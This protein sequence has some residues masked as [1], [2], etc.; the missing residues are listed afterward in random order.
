M[1]GSVND[2]Y[3]H[4]SEEN[5]QLFL[6]KLL[7]K[8]VLSPGI[9]ANLMHLPLYIYFFKLF[10]YQKMPFQAAG[11]LSIGND[12]F[13]TH[14]PLSPWN[15]EN[16]NPD[17]SAILL[18]LVLLVPAHLFYSDSHWYIFKYLVKPIAVL[19]KKHSRAVLL[20]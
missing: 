17:L 1:L 5:Q 19:S 3:M 6:K 13:D 11:F 14:L 7:F 16:Y 15:P 8:E 10:P 12:S 9:D 20:L 2:Y 18:L 4:L